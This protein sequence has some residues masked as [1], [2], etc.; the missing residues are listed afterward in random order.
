VKWQSLVE[1]ATPLPTPWPKDCY[2]NAMSESQ[3]LI[4]KL[5]VENRLATEIEEARRK[6]RE[7]AQHCLSSGP[8]SEKVGVFE[9]AM[10]ETK[11]YYRPQ[12]QCLMISGKQ[13]CAVCR[14]AIEE[15]IDL[16][17]SP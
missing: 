3:K 16:Y 17:S 15:I 7:A 2:E 10:Y 1:S 14:H 6:A 13:F 4:D 11:G 5:R 9:G 12:Q 8:Y